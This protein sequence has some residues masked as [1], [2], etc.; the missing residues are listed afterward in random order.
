M[1]DWHESQGVYWRS[2]ECKLLLKEGKDEPR[3]IPKPPLKTEPVAD[4][5][6][7]IRLTTEDEVLAKFEMFNHGPRADVREVFKLV[8]FFC[9]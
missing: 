5:D 6:E 7:L 2:K 8:K 3:S 4:W 9:F 1:A